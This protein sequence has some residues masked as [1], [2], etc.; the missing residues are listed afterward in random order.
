MA[1]LQLL[2]ELSKH[3]GKT[4]TGISVN[5]FA[6]IVLDVVVA[7]GATVDAVKRLE[8]HI[9]TKTEDTALAPVAVVFAHVVMAS[10]AA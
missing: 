7:V 2:K 8:I 5:G 9:G 1:P 4:P 6:R 3:G 10:N